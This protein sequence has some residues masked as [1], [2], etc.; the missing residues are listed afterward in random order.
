MCQEFLHPEFTAKFLW[1]LVPKLSRSK[2]S[3][4]LLPSQS[5]S[6]PASFNCTIPAAPAAWA[7]QLLPAGCLPPVSCGAL[8]EGWEEGSLSPRERPSAPRVS[9]LLLSTLFH[10][11]RRKRPAQARGIQWEPLPT[12]S[13]PPLAILPMATAIRST[14]ASSFPPASPAA[15]AGR[16][17]WSTD[18]PGAARAAAQAGKP[19]SHQ[20]NSSILLT[21]PAGASCAAAPESGSLLLTSSSREQN[22]DGGNLLGIFQGTK[23]A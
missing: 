15:R 5:S 17:S 16:S 20:Q 1:D 11:S 7:P 3:S 10:L 4:S 21:S 2:G 12:A 14:G 13:W 23:N 22:T 6:L 8:G 18:A 9:C 19:F